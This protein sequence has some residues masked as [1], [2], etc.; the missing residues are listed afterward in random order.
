[1]V[2]IIAVVVPSPAFAGS[3]AE[4]DT[5]DVRGP[6]TVVIDGREYGPKDGLQVDTFQIEVEPGSEPVG[7]VFDDTM[8]NA[9]G[10][11]VPLATWGASYAISTETIQLFY[12]GKAK[13]AAN[14]YAGKRI[15]QVCIWYTRDGEQKGNKVCS[16]ATTSGTVWLPGPEKKTSCWD[17]LVPWDPPTIFNFTTVRI[18]PGII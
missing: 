4:S 1:M 15:I 11:I 17:S 2:L 8:S 5:E 12:E 18:D 10:S 14:I 16:N 13:A 3:P 9:P 7:L 6:K